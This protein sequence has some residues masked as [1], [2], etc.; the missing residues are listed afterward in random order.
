VTWGNGTTGVSGAVDNTVN[1]FTGLMMSDGVG[2]GGVDA[3]PSGNFVVRSPNWSGGGAG[4]GAVTWANGTVPLI[5]SPN[6]L[7]NSIVGG[8]AGDRIGG[9]NIVILTNGNYVF[10]SPSWDNGGAS[11]AGAV[12]YAID[13]VTLTG[14]VSPANSLVGTTT[15]DGVGV[16]RALTNGHY[17]VFSPNWNNGVPGQKV[18]AVTWANGTTGK[19]GPVLASE[20]L[21]GSQMND[22]VGGTLGIA[23]SNG[24]YVVI[25]PDWNNGSAMSAGAVTLCDGTGPTVG[26]VSPTNSIVGTSS[27]DQIGIYDVQEI[28]V[29]NFVIVSP[30]WDNGLLIDAGAVTLGCPTT[31]GPVSASNSVIGLAAMTDLDSSTINTVNG[32]LVAGFIDEGSGIVRVLVNNCQATPTPVSGGATL[33]ASAIREAL[34]DLYIILS[35]APQTWSA[36]FYGGYMGENGYAPDATYKG[37]NIFIPSLVHFEPFTPVKLAVKE[38]KKKIEKELRKDNQ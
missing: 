33:S 32:S 15:G 34:N 7:T 9:S 26:V 6:S 10:S 36:T 16:A 35:E 24:N 31:V 5:G 18:G 8:T 4:L 14:T 3:L 25:S 2:G 20:S 19:V 21:I 11:N 29:G 37:I 12:T 30:D 13:G 38:T 17:V 23:L 22:M 1:S 27:M 28:G